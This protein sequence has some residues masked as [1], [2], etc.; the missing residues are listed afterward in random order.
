MFLSLLI[1]DNMENENVR[2]IIT[3]NAVF[4][5]LNDVKSKNIEPIIRAA[6]IANLGFFELSKYSCLAIIV[7]KYTLVV[8]G[9]S[10][11]ELEAINLTHHLIPFEGYEWKRFVLYSIIGTAKTNHGNCNRLPK[12][13]FKHRFYPHPSIM[14]RASSPLRGGNNG[15]IATR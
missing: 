8:E 4:S 10:L 15:R 11:N 6:L 3:N 9:G 13:S 5:K 7:S 2:N 12:T 14:L 1:N